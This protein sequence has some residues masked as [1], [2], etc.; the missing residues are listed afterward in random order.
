MGITK[1]A[2][3]TEE[4][5]DWG[6]KEL[7]LVK[8]S[9][10]DKDLSVLYDKAYEAYCN[11]VENIYDDDID[12]LKIQIIKTIFMQFINNEPLTPIRDNEDDWEV[13]DKEENDEHKYLIYKCKRR[14][15]LFKKVT[16]DKNN[17]NIINTK[18]SDTGRYMCV[19]INTG[20]TYVGGLAGLIL[21]ETIPITMP[22]SPIGKIKIY[23]EDFKCYD[24]KETDPD[25]I[26]ILYLQMPDGQ[27]QEKK[28]FFKKDQ[29]T[30]DMVEIGLTEYLSRKKRAENL[31][32]GRKK[33]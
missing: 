30:E 15:T 17:G 25:T 6:E 3:I 14:Y 11:F 12:V 29:K 4:K 8:D 23:T 10:D 5:K 27:I 21:D 28:R 1:I 16:Y 24:D 32:L 18:F 22:Y 7:K 2:N 26:G 31:D 19:D 9:L 20:K 33:K 13:V